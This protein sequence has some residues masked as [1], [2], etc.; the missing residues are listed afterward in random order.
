VVIGS[1]IEAMMTTSWRRWRSAPRCLPACAAA[2]RAYRDALRE[3]HVVG[4]MGD[5][6]NDAPAARRRTSAS[7]SMGGYRPRAADIILLE[8]A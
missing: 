3:G 7:R 4:F 8:K 2:Q 1:Q 5:G 6:I